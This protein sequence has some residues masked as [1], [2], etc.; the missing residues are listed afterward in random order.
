MPAL[1][2]R[3]SSLGFSPRASRSR[4]LIVSRSRPPKASSWIRYAI[5]RP[6]MSLVRPFGGT[7]PNI[8]APTFAK[9]VD[10]EG[11]NLVRPRPRSQR[12]QRSADPWLGG[13]LRR[14]QLAAASSLRQ[15]SR[16]RSGRSRSPSIFQAFECQTELLA[17]YTGEE[18]AN[19][20]LLPA[21]R[22]HDGGD[23]RALRAPEQGQD[24]VLLGIARE[25]SS[26]AFLAAT[27][28]L[29][30]ACGFITLACAAD[31][32]LNFGAFVT[33]SHSGFGYGGWVPPP[34][35][36]RGGRRALAGVRERAGLGQVSRR[37]LIRLAALSSVVTS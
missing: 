7:A 10:A 28:F 23:C 21:C 6:M 19:R 36:P 16:R 20:V 25:V 31:F 22:L 12:H 33:M 18:S 35:Q 27:F 30:E 4:S 3:F 13:L 32:C 29:A 15:T 14:P 24:L 26:T 11:P 17:H 37:R 5:I 2:R 8:S 9:R 1:R 34:P